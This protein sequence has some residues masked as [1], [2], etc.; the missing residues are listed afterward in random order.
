MREQLWEL[1]EEW[2]RRLGQAGIVDFPD[3]VRRARDLARS[4]QEPVYRAA[5]VDESQDLTLVGLQLIRALVGDAGGRDQRDAL[6]ISE[7][8]VAMTRARDGLFVLYS[9]EPSDVLIEALDHFE[10]EA[11]EGG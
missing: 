5:I 8:F 11:W 6:E 3:V 7:L 1:R 4:R 10:V 2:D 9:N